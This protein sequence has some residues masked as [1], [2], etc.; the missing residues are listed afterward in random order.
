MGVV[1]VWSPQKFKLGYWTPKS[2]IYLATY[3][4][5]NCELV[6]QSINQSINLRLLAACQNAG[7]QCT[8]SKT[9][10]IVQKFKS[11]VPNICDEIGV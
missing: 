9:H 5:L 11:Y 2:L 6:Y 3:N 8:I 1:R 10:T 7:Q 4:A